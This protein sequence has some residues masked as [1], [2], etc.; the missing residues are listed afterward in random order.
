MLNYEGILSAHITR[1]MQNRDTNPKQYV[2]GIETLIIHTPKIVR[3]KALKKIQDLGL[4]LR[5][6]GELSA[7]RLCV[8]DDLLIY[9]NEELEDVNLIFRTGTFEVGH[10]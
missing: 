2:S 8:Y 6:Y 4:Q 7:Q 1:L 3:A 9:I 10:D 5:A